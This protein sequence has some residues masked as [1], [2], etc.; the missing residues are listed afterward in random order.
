MKAKQPDLIALLKPL[1][2]AVDQIPKDVSDD[3]VAHIYP[4]GI[5]VTVADLRAASKAVKLL[6]APSGNA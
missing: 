6:K 1:A 2:K 5:A 4:Y 3:F